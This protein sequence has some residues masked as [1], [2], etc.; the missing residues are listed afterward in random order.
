MQPEEAVCVA[1]NEGTQGDR[2]RAWCK[3]STTLCPC[4]RT[5]EMALRRAQQCSA[6]S[7]ER[8]PRDLL[9]QVPQADVAQPGWCYRACAHRPE[10]LGGFQGRA[11]VD[12]VPRDLCPSLLLDA[13]LLHEPE[14]CVALLGPRGS[15]SPRKPIRASLHICLAH[16]IDTCLPF[17]PVFR[18]RGVYG[19]DMRD[20]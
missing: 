17:L 19:E 18:G 15:R 8:P 14:G 6:P 10:A 11:C 13:L 12:G 2:A 5:V 16:R 7:W 1:R 3:A 9:F 20:V 4:F